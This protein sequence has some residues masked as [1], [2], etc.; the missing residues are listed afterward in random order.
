MGVLFR[1]PLLTMMWVH[2]FLLLV[3]P[4]FLSY[5][6]SWCSLLLLIYPSF[7]R[8][9]FHYVHFC[10]I[11]CEEHA[12]S[13]SWRGHCSS[14]WWI[15]VSIT[16]WSKRNYERVSEFFGEIWGWF[17]FTDSYACFL[18]CAFTLEKQCF[19]RCAHY[20]TRWLLFCL[21]VAITTQ[22]STIRATCELTQIQ[23]C[24]NMLIRLEQALFWGEWY[25]WVFRPPLSYELVCWLYR[26]YDSINQA[27]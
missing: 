26:I 27:K 13:F 17:I 19:I 21:C 25:F 9:T 5:H 18:N 8:T 16:Q 12:W 22:I 24:L 11:D 15:R 10:L 1:R 7:L 14:C 2:L 3:N 4:S 23:N 20:H 6:I